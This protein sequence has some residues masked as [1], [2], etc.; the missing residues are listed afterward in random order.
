ML[1]PHDRQP[2]PPRPKPT[3]PKPAAK[4]RPVKAKGSSAPSS[5]RRAAST[6][7]QSTRLPKSDDD[8]VPALFGD[9]DLAYEI[10]DTNLRYHVQGSDSGW[11]AISSMPRELRE[12]GWVYLQTGRN[13]AA[14]CRVKGIGFRDRRW[15]HEGPGDTFDAG[16]GATLE[17]YGDGWEYVS[18]DLGPD[19]DVEVDGYRYL[20]T[21]PD[22]SVHLP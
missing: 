7:R 16:P 9:R 12:S 4:R 22:G 15:T 14:R 21:E 8:A 1:L 6:P 11:L 3:P 18:I 10:P 2:E 20:I 17:L 19:G 5:A 13:L